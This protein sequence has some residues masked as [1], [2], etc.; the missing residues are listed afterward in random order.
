M[1]TKFKI[2]KNFAV[3][4]DFK[5]DENVRKKDDSIIEF[6]DINILYGRNYSGKTSLSRLVDALN[7][8]EVSDKYGDLECVLSLIDG[9][10]VTHK[11]FK[12]HN[13]TIRVFNED[14][15]KKNLKFI[16]DPD[17]DVLPIAIMGESSLRVEEEIRILRTKLGNKE[18][19][20]KTGLYKELEILES[21]YLSKIREYESKKDN[22][23]KLLGKKATGRDI[24]IKYNAKFNKINY[25]IRD[26]ERDINEV[27]EEAYIPISKVQVNNFE[28]L[29]TESIKGEIPKLKKIELTF[30]QL[31]HKTKN[32]IAQKVVK[33]DKIEDLV[34]HATLNR[35]VEE[36]KKLHEGQRNICAFCNNKITQDRWTELNRHFDKKSEMLK[37]SIRDLLFEI[38]AEEELIKNFTFFSENDIYSNFTEDYLTTFKMYKTCETGYLNALS[39][40]KKVLNE[41]YDDILNEKLLTKPKDYSADLVSNINKLDDIRKKSNKYTDKLISEQEGA[42]KKLRLNEVSN[43]IKTINYDGEQVKINTLR[44]EQ[45]QAKNSRD[46]VQD[47]IN[48]IIDDISAKQMSLGEEGIGAK[49]I[50]DYLN[51]HFGNESLEIIPIKYKDKETGNEISRF[52]IQRKNKKAYHLSEGEKSLLAFCYFLAKLEEI[53]TKNKNP[54]IWI[55]DPISS[56]DGNHIFFLYSLIKSE[57]FNEKE[58]KQLFVSTH[59]LN[60]LKYLKRLPSHS[61]RD[62]TN[63]FMIERFGEK[64][65]ISEMPM[66]LQKNIT[67]FNYLFKKIYDCANINKVTDDNYTVFYDFGNNARKFLEIYLFYKYPDFTDDSEKLKRFFG[68]DDIPVILTERVNNEYSHLV[69]QIERGQEPVEVPEMKKVAEL[70]LKKIMSNDP[71]QFKSLVKSIE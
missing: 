46:K 14:F 30:H 48:K 70:I 64:S 38:E 55:D 62:K 9:T 20:K 17:K 18:E 63:Y 21:S 34:K 60:F 24:G 41:R 10:E 52:E 50:N 6:Q 42:R 44:K 39:E 32:I 35:W 29:L 26:L 5:W 69:A 1:I 11:N 13:E 4:Q 51:N 2:I 47:S 31:V 19:P 15:I 54:I 61:Y 37:K 49:K 40:L 16:N 28:K 45:N 23:N 58:F 8:G 66:Y 43:F 67:E 33:T 36:G 22:L 25:D 53:G 68:E 12:K 57:I 7:T 71:E 3:F 65:I 59:N 27:R 56:L